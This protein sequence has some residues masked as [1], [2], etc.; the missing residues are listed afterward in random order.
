[1]PGIG[2]LRAEGE[3]RQSRPGHLLCYGISRSCL[4]GGAGS[5]GGMPVEENLQPGM[6]AQGT[7]AV[8]YDARGYGDGETAPCVTG[9]H[10]RRVS[11]YTSIVATETAAGYRNDS[12]GGG[13][14][15]ILP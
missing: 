4:K 5:N 14:N 8:C 1:M 12:S 6:V 3:N 11:D 2:C 15:S 7:G 9:D 13:W 10:E